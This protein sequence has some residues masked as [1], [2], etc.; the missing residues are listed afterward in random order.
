M[1]HSI[2]PAIEELERAYQHFNKALFN[3]S[4]DEKILITIQSRGTKKGT[5]AWYWAEKWENSG[6]NLHEINI[7]AE[8][9]KSACPYHSLIH[10]MVHHKNAL[11]G[12]KGTSRGGKYHNK[13]FKLA[14]EQ[15][16]LKVDK[17][18]KYG[19]AFTSMDDYALNA[20]ADLTP[21][22]E[23][24]D[25]LRREANKKPSKNNLKKYDCGCTKFYAKTDVFADCQICG[26]RFIES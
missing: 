2:I 8:V 6:G 26:S 15:A 10:E 16:G 24:F 19:F 14:A 11:D 4:L 23:V 13:N 18:D 7:V 5:L 1:Q 22:S 21:R 17:D 20:L 3:G 9:I 12:V 25:C